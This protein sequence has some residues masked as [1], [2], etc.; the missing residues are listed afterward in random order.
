MRMNLTNKNN[1]QKKKK[2]EKRK[3]N[4]KTTTKEK[5]RKVHTCKTTKMLQPQ[6]RKVEKKQINN[7]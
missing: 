3:Q 2:I 7:K 4:G 5:E 6:Q 1:E